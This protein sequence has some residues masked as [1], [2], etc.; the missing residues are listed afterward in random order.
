MTGSKSKIKSKGRSRG[1]VAFLGLLVL[2]CVLF[3][4]AAGYVARS[5]LRSGESVLSLI[6]FEPGLIARCRDAGEFWDTVRSSPRYR[7]FVA[8]PEGKAFMAASPTARSVRSFNERGRVLGCSVLDLLDLL[9]EETIIVAPSLLSGQGSFLFAS[10]I[11]PRA[12]L[13]A[14][15]YAE[16][17]PTLPLRTP[18]GEWWAVVDRGAG[19]AWTKV[20]DVLAGSNDLD[21]LARFAATALG[22]RREMP[23]LADVLADD[24]APQIALRTLKPARGE[25]PAGHPKAIVISLRPG[26]RPAAAKPGASAAFEQIGSD[27]ISSDI[28]A[29]L[30]WRLDLASIW[31]LALDTRSDAG[32]EHMIRYAEDRICALLDAEDFEKD[33]LGRL[34]GDC[35]VAVS[36]RSD[37]WLSLAA[38]GPMPAVSFVAGVRSDPH[39]ERQL[40]VALVETVG[41][42]V[43]GSKE[44]ET[45]MSTTKYQ[46][47]SI[48]LVHV[49]R[50]GQQ[51]GAAAGYFIAPDKRRPGQSVIVISTSSAWLRQ[52]ID[53]HDG[54]ATPLSRE[55]WA[56]GI[57]PSV[58]SDRPV[59]GFVNGD[60][61]LDV[62]AR[63]RGGGRGGKGSVVGAEQWL[64]ALGVI[65]L[66]GSVGKDG[67]VRAELR[68][69]GGSEF[70]D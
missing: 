36:A 33:V 24:D 61:L 54:R 51:G 12:N 29:G 62:L 18:V 52:A 67:V 60:G 2:S 25:A 37:P 17:K 63:I 34:T 40:R 31:R 53:V 43:Q 69:S 16:L 55:A 13:L 44:F 21:L 22:N 10:R 47:R 56:G 30:A 38:G 39:F 48:T 58:V 49:W 14:G 27:Y 41:A 65:A 64:S 7:E 42:L 59:L 4:W 57:A 19:I 46:G 11:G 28:C 32:R 5:P 45:R 66:D 68:F 3:A 9:G 8:S 6:D 26:E 50:R 23:S 35:V 70:T 15:L 20:G 1:K